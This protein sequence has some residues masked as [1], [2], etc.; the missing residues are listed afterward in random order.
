MRRVG[1]VGDGLTGLVASLSVGSNGGEAAL[2]GRSEPMGGL[3]SPVDPEATWLFDQIPIF[4]RRKG[5]LARL[6]KRMK[7][8]MPTREL[9]LSKMAI[10][11]N[12]QRQTLPHKVGIL[13][14]PTGPFAADWVTMIQMA[15]SGKVAQLEGPIRDVAI[16]L[17]LLWDCRPE[18][19]A[20][21][22]LEFAWKGRPTVPIDGWSGVSGR[23]ITACLQT[24]VTFHLDGPVTGYRRKKN[25]QIDGVRRKGRVLPVDSVI[26]A[27][28]RSKSAIFGRYLGLSGHFLRPHAVLWD[29][30]REVLLVDL[31]GIAPERVPSEY[32]E[33]STLLHCIAFGDLAN[34]SSR[35]EDCLDTQCSG[36]RGSI[37]ED[38]SRNNLRLPIPPE[39]NFKNGIH[40]ANLD[41]AYE[42][43]KTALNHE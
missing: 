33:S 19:N 13:R 34:S 3:A 17:S 24:D 41:N 8:P 16:L 43:G 38:F 20:D 42:V 21:A 23:L 6:L 12:D 2:F 26:K 37:V 28:S 32:R 31:A 1:V 4:W 9:S 15:R 18:P 36:W 39:S 11:R 10:I 29:V 25:G 27:S 22:I 7:V 35:I 40:F 30:D 14:R 5:H